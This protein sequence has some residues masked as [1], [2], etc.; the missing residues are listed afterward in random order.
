MI[1]ISWASD[2]AVV[3]TKAQ[4]LSSVLISLNGDFADIA[5]YPPRSEF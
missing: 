2:D 5:T 1:L 4:E 3:I